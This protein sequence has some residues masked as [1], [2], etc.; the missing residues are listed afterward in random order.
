MRDS[1]ASKNLRRT[2][3]IFIA[4]VLSYVVI[5]CAPKNH[6]R[7]EH[8]GA[9]APY[10]PPQTP[11]QDDVKPQEFNDLDVASL[12]A[13]SE[14]LATTNQQIEIL[15]S[16]ARFVLNQPFVENPKYRGVKLNQM[17]DAFNR[18]FFMVL[19]AE[20]DGPSTQAFS[21]GL[22]KKD[23]L[24]TVFAGCSR[25][26]KN[27]CQ[28]ADL[29]S[30]NGLHTSIM[31]ILAQEL[32]GQIDSLLTKFESPKKCIKESDECRNAIEERYR[33]LAMAQ[34]KRNQGGNSE[35]EFAYLKYARLFA[36]LLDDAKFKIYGGQMTD[37]K[38]ELAEKTDAS[39][40][41]T[42]Y[43]RGTHSQIFESIIARYQPLDIQSGEFKK[44][45]ENFN[46]WIYS[47]KT[48]DVFRFGI[49]KMFHYGAQ[50]CLYEDSEK[51][52]LSKAVAEAIEVSQA[53]EDH[54]GPS[55]RQIVSY[56]K[57]K[58]G[59]QIFKNL[60]VSDLLR[61]IEDPKSDF[62]NEYFFLVDRLFREHLG[63][64]EVEMVLKTTNSKRTFVEL[65]KMV[66]AYIRVYM[67]Y[68]VVR[69]NEYMSQIYSANIAS[70]QVFEES[71][72]RSRGLTDQWHT[73]QSQ[74]SLLDS[75]MGAYFK[76]RFTQTP[77]YTDA[78]ALALSV[79]RNIHYLSVFPN[80]M[81][82]VYFLSKMK[83]SIVFNTWYG[84]VEIDANTILDAFF[85]GNILR[86]W[87]VFGKDPELISRE[88][89]LYSIDFLLST[90][91]LNSFIDKDNTQNQLERRSLFFDTVLGRYL[92]DQ[93]GDIRTEIAK[94]EGE[95]KSSPQKALAEDICQ[96]EK[97]GKGIPP[98]IEISI[99]DLMNFTY[100][101][102]GDNGI[103][104]VLTK[105]LI[106]TNSIA[107]TLRG[108]FE[109]RATF[110]R[111][112]IDLIE[113]DLLRNGQISQKGEAHPE[114]AKAYALLREIDELKLA[115]QKK[116]LSTNQRYFDCAIRL[117]EIE[118]RRTNRLY[119]AERE[120][121]GSIYDLLAPLREIQDPDKLDQEVKRINESEFRKPGWMDSADESLRKNSRFDRV[122]GLSFLMSK[123]DLMMRMKQR[124]ESDIFKTPSQKEIDT[125]GGKDADYYRPRKVKIYLP[126][127][128]E[129]DDMVAK[130]TT[131]AITVG[132][133]KE[134]FVTQ[135]MAL[136]NGRNLS[137]IRWQAQMASETT[138][139]TY[140]AALIE[141]FMM[142]PVVDDKDDKKEGAVLEVTE[143][144]LV[145]A[146]TK[147]LALTTLDELDL[148]NLKQFGLEGLKE[149]AYFKERLLDTDGRTPLALYYRLVDDVLGVAELKQE[150]TGPHGVAIRFAK[151]I[152]N[153]QTFVFQPTP[154]VR[155]S[156]VHHYGDLSHQRINQVL[157]LTSLI[158][159]IEEETRDIRDLEE[160]K[161]TRPI[162]L[163][164]DT[165]VYWYS[166]GSRLIFD[167]QHFKNLE[168][169]IESFK[170]ATGNL[171]GT[172]EK[173]K[174]RWEH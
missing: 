3:S 158:Q 139:N 38:K 102:L 114:T 129:R 132:E 108:R 131:T 55:F 75:V 156:V 163:D 58:Q 11:T 153:L 10:V 36:L 52:K 33:R 125:Y 138:L 150:G 142:G 166:R 26:L 135:G 119:D 126:D 46:P 5:G 54:F 7:Q 2:G 30:A 72:K 124:V 56:I 13:K 86:T 67:I 127:G 85:D 144:D 164:G 80:M 78:S 69:T 128:I 134:V 79:N 115:L 65:P 161:F 116:F 32:D 107:S 12:S 68:M 1:N 104:R 44:F 117:R 112:M 159:K 95:T 62:Y 71:I 31:T 9:V 53:E 113:A 27:D 170:S 66:S 133:S 39:S 136:L 110:T 171:Y 90:G 42:G 14:T 82:M 169:R 120:Y 168:T 165:P 63:S 94:F 37:D 50:C 89:L 105:G 130:G 64:A 157:K 93:L 23:Y 106:G 160:G 4:L 84:K 141:H 162:Y 70:S 155:E 103:A 35:F 43:I 48:S 146:Y 18:S 92:G 96:Y 8:D 74:I 98:G 47:A 22:L 147:V 174:I 88:M 49:K 111:A 123:Y 97:S 87:Y 81:V 41:L 83:G 167:H 77:E 173:V 34:K 45:V 151:Q 145:N 122:S 59:S 101:G 28:N 60:G 152:N 91:A 99:H 148:E 21:V 51:T 6:P 149:R 15:K 172:R 19:T 40:F 73:I 143:Q 118:R 109:Y 76:G 17:I 154:Q 16:L 140:I 24:D 121:L 29:F 61:Q 20:K 25:D 137:Y 100:S 57:Q